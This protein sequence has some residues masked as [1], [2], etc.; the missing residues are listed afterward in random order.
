MEVILLS[1]FWKREQLGIVIWEE[2]VFYL[3]CA[4]DFL[5]CECAVKSLVPNTAFRLVDE[6]QTP[7]DTVWPP[8]SYNSVALCDRNSGFWLVRAHDVH[9]QAP[10]RS[11]AE[12]AWHITVSA[13]PNRRRFPLKRQNLTALFIML[14]I[15]SFWGNFN[16]QKSV[17]GRIS[18]YFMSGFSKTNHLFPRKPRKLTQSWQYQ[19][20]SEQNNPIYLTCLA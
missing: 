6:S 3:N 12:S 5:F 20:F 11:R 17:S 13:H 9:I 4:H 2:I 16:P 14:K 18:T 1:V 19:A 8:T 10:I 7:R 15:T